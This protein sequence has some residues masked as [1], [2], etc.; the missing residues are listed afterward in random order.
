MFFVIARQGDGGQIQLTVVV[1]DDPHRVSTVVEVAD[2][3]GN[4]STEGMASGG[5][6]APA[7]GVG[8][9]TARYLEGDEAVRL[10]VATM[11]NTCDVGLQF[12][13][14]SDG[15]IAVDLAGDVLFVTNTQMV[16]AG[17]HVPAKVSGGIGNAGSVRD[18]VGFTVHGPVVEVAVED[19]ITE[20]AFGHCLCVC[21]IVPVTVV[22][23]GVDGEGQ[24]G[25]ESDIQFQDAVAAPGHRNKGGSCLRFR[26]DTAIGSPDIE[27]VTSGVHEDFLSQSLNVE[28][29]QTAVAVP[30]YLERIIAADGE[31]HPSFVNTLQVERGAIA[32]AVPLYICTCRRITHCHREGVNDMV[33]LLLLRQRDNCCGDDGGIQ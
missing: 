3:V 27:T 21:C 24:C 13:G 28:R 6:A 7:D 11:V 20:T 25:R 33:H 22:V 26:I 31:F 14:F 32:V 30:H 2:G 17:R 12:A 5:G 1:I 29:H 19:S 9:C 18:G 15:N 10:V 4:S 16:G 8:Q 23:M